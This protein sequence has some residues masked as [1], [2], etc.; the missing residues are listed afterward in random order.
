M[1]CSRSAQVQAAEKGAGAEN[2]LVAAENAGQR[3]FRKGRRA[4]G[5][6]SY[7][8]LRRA[9]RGRDRIHCYSA[10]RRGGRRIECQRRNADK[11]VGEHNPVGIA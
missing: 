6:R 11:I 8:E 5:N 9:P 7:Q 2:A 4:A 3:S 10:T 1:R